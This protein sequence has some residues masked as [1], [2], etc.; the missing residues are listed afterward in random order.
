MSNKYLEETYKKFAEGDGA[1]MFHFMVH[2]YKNM[3][4]GSNIKHFFIIDGLWALTEYSYELM[5]KYNEDIQKELIQWV[6]NEYESNELFRSDNWK[7]FRDQTA[8]VS[9]FMG[10]KK[11][12]I[13]KN[14]Y[15][16]LVLTDDI[17]CETC[18]YCSQ[19]GHVAIRFQLA[20]YGWK[21]DGCDT[22]LPRKWLRVLPDNCT[23]DQLWNINY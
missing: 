19:E 23:P 17:S 7:A 6:H 3:I 22:L 18:E 1:D 16:Q 9:F 12:F 10:Y 15:L 8:I 11:M 14:Y 13:Y 5:E 4:D 21:E 20:L 2:N